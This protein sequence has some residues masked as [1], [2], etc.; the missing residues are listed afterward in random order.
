M[1]FLWTGY[2]SARHD[3]WPRPL[4]VDTLPTVTTCK[5][6]TGKTP[7]FLRFTEPC[8]KRG[9]VQLVTTPASQSALWQVPARR[10]TPAGRGAWTRFQSPNK[11]S[12]MRAGAERASAVKR[13]ANLISLFL[14]ASDEVDQSHKRFDLEFPSNRH[15]AFRESVPPW[16]NQVAAE[17]TSNRSYGRR[18]LW[19]AKRTTRCRPWRPDVGA[20]YT[21][22]RGSCGRAKRMSGERG[23]R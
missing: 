5:A 13:G 21:S 11:C 4:S 6:N 15:L 14:L 1:P 17:L 3:F 19:S 20:P 10:F 9:V 23:T 12:I 2:L 16:A 8:D 7:R 18:R 22:G